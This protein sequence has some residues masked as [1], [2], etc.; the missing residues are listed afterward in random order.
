ML[1]GLL[2][3]AI[4][5]IFASLIDKI[6]Y[7]I[8]F[9]I[10]ARSLTKVEFG[11]Y[12]LVLTLIFIGGMIVN[13]GMENVIIREVARNRSQA[14]L[15]FSNSIFLGFIFSLISWPMMMILAHI[16][17]YGPEVIFLM[18]FGGVTFIFMG[19]GQI[20]S[21]VIK[22]HERMDVFA[23]VSVCYSIVA[24]GLNMVALW[25]WSTVASLVV[26]LFVTEALKATTFVAI[27]HRYFVQ[28]RWQLNRGIIIQIL[29]LSVPFALLMAFGVLLHRTDML[30]LGWLK[31]LDE[32]AIYGMAAR[33]TD[34]LS[35]ISGSLIGALYPTLS[36]KMNAT[37][38]EQ[39][40]L[41]KESMAV[42]AICGF[43]ASILLIVLAEPIILM[44]FG[45][46]YIVGVST[47]RWLG[48][49]FLFSMLSGPVGTLL[50]AAGDQMK[51]LMV[52]G[53]V[54]LG[55]SIVL[56]L[57]LIPA[58]SYKG[59]AISAFSCTVL[60]FLFRLALSRIYF[61]R[62]PHLLKIMW[63][64]VVASSVMG[65]TLSFCQG[66]HPGMSLVVGGL[67]YIT[68]LLLLGEFSEARYAPIKVRILQFLRHPSL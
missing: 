1:A 52:M 29:K 40:S 44:L 43:G 23:A 21:A 30:M 5:L 61:G 6:A 33:F 60:G 27:V 39:W 54:L 67:V 24:L 36:A 19:F 45:S 2:K 4:S 31:P 42:F 28:I 10:I 65:I 49:A 63:R 3:N 34:F 58:Y 48:S 66:F 16:L 20:A 51:R 9:I 56:N 37:R 26:V 41:I 46:P 17:K 18:S 11:A 55:S 68:M 47:L 13:F 57:W 53:A 62:L 38:E 25:Y 32:V 14:R 50:L 8:L 12:N 15:Y 22:G 35:L 59:A 7:A 64:A